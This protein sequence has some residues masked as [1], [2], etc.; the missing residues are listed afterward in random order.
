MVAPDLGYSK[1]QSPAKARANY[2]GVNLPVAKRGSGPSN[3]DESFEANPGR[4]ADAESYMAL[5]RQCELQHPEE[6]KYLKFVVLRYA[7][8][9][10]LA[11][12]ARKMKVSPD[13]AKG[14]MTKTLNFLEAYI[15]EQ[16]QET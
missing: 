10:S 11:K 2:A 1:A 8:G 3:V 9:W 4:M 16:E 12:V 13:T 5:V 7:E 15:R 14:R 6:C